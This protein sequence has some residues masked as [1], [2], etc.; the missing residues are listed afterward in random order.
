LDIYHT[1]T[2]PIN[3]FQGSQ[4]SAGAMYLQPYI[5]NSAVVCSPVVD[6]QNAHSKNHVY[7]CY[8]QNYTV[9]A[10]LELRQELQQVRTQSPAWALEKSKLGQKP[11]KAN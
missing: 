2:V 7:F 10:T 5:V 8:L 4:Y 3:G 1:V 11:E 9:E 6:K